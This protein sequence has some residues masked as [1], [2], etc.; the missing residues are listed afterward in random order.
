MMRFV[1]RK[2]YIYGCVDAT[3]DIKGKCKMVAIDGCKKSKVGT[4]SDSF[5][6]R[7]VPTFS[8]IDRSTSAHATSSKYPVEKVTFF[9]SGLLFCHFVLVVPAEHFLTACCFFHLS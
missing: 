2:V 7:S 1:P 5:V 3:I 9:F 4:S 8:S 6:S